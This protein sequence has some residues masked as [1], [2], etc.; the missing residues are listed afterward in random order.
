MDKEITIAKLKEIINH[1]PDDAPVRI[2][3]GHSL[4]A[5]VEYDYVAD[6]RGYPAGI[7]LSNPNMPK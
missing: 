5:A 6:S 1:L 7:I 4:W 2:C 3:N